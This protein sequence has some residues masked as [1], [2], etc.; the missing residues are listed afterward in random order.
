MNDTLFDYLDDFCT[1]Y[2]DDI[3]IYSEDPLE[4][5]EHVCKVLERLRDAS[6][7]ADIRKSEFH[8]QQTKYL[9]FI[10]STD[11]IKTDLEKTSVI[12]Q[13]EPPRSVKGV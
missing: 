11:S 12:Q 9:G 1:A 7:Q 5:E 4:H 8:V 2:L 10:V 13:W 6:L 3:I